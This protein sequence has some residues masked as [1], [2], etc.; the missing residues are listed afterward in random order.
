MYVWK[1]KDA[2]VSDAF[3]GKVVEKLPKWLMNYENTE[4]ET[5]DGVANQGIS[6]HKICEE[7]H[8]ALGGTKC[9]KA[10]MANELWVLVVPDFHW[11][12]LLAFEWTWS[13][14]RQN[15]ETH[16]QTKTQSE[17]STAASSMIQGQ[18]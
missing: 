4:I 11:G 3:C 5:E 13:R 17:Q 18:A 15:T 16:R 9:G 12:W 8:E 6:H 2:S 1:L 7:V 10:M 14:Y